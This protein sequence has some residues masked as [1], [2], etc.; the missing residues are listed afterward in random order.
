MPS[1]Q[2][3]AAR[4][5]TAEIMAAMKAGDTE[6]ANALMGRNES[7]S[8]ILPGG[9]WLK[10]KIHGKGKSGGGAVVVEQ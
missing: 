9:G 1:A 8:G 3:Q 7:G 4:D 10:R 2:A 6:R 5:K